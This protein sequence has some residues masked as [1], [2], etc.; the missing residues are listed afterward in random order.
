MHSQFVKQGRN[1]VVAQDHIRLKE[2]YTKIHSDDYQINIADI[3][4]KL[5]YH[6]CKYNRRSTIIFLFQMYFDIFTEGDRIG[7]RQSFNYGKFLIK[8]KATRNWYSRFLLPI[9]RYS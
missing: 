4:L 6:A 5:F 7:L 2:L 3:Y 8:D 1:A 9:L